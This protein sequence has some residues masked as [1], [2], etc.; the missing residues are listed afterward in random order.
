[1]EPYIPDATGDELYTIAS[2]LQMG[3]GG[4]RPGDYFGPPEQDSAN[5]ARGHGPAKL[6][7]PGKRAPQYAGR[8]EMMLDDPAINELFTIADIVRLAQQRPIWGGDYAG[9]A[10]YGDSDM[11][12]YF[13]RT[14]Y[15]QGRKMPLRL[16][17]LLDSDMAMQ[18][19]AGADPYGNPL[20]PTWATP[21]RR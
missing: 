11:E 16:S 6:T 15:Q 7:M 17:D 4:L 14:P 20:P 10:G 2:L 19:L 1:M 8:P 12:E 5:Y 9:P 18:D 3:R 13:D 21:R